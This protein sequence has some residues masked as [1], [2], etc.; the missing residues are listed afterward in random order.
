MAGVD[1]DLSV[2]AIAVPVVVKGIPC[3]S[4]RRIDVA[5]FDRGVRRRVGV[6]MGESGVAIW[7]V[8]SGFGI[9]GGRG[10]TTWTEGFWEAGVSVEF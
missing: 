4:A 9:L 3:A 8:S 6:R 1:N 2:A 7:K 5:G 10:E